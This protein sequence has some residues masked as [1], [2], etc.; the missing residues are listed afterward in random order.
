MSKSQGF[1]PRKTMIRRYYYC[2]N[3]SNHVTKVKLKKYGEKT[4][5]GIKRY[6]YICP[7]CNDLYFKSQTHVTPM[8]LGEESI[9][10]SNIDSP[11][12]NSIGCPNCGSVAVL[13][14]D[15]NEPIEKYFCNNCYTAISVSLDGKMEIYPSIEK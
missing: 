2:N 8:R 6:L 10:I 5:N 7:E 15:K 9:L 13:A 14:T 4:R 11:T 3:F 1:Y 12:N